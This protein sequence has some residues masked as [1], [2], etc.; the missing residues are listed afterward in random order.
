M[1]KV[2]NIDGAKSRY[3]YIGGTRGVIGL[4]D[5]NPQSDGHTFIL[6]DGD[7]L[8]ISGYLDEI[9]YT[10]YSYGEG[11][12]GY[13]FIIDSGRFSNSYWYYEYGQSQ[14]D[15]LCQS[16][17][18]V[19]FD[20]EAMRNPVSYV[21]IYILEDDI[22]TSFPEGSTEGYNDEQAFNDNADWIYKIKLSYQSEGN[23]WI[24][25]N[26]WEK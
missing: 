17:F 26:I 7:T 13:Y 3:C 16:G 9:P 19:L 24:L 21:I 6:P 2:I 18:N 25:D 23:N 22:Y 1:S 14:H 15:M 12:D 5:Y 11:S 8:W 20:V 4:R 10:P